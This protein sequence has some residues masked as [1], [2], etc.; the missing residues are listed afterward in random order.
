MLISRRSL[1]A[2]T[3]VLPVLTLP[4]CAG[5][6]GGFNLV[7]VIRRLLSLS[8]QRAFASLMSENGFL[9]SQVARISLPAQFGGQAASGIVGTLL[10]SGLVRDRLTRTVN[11]AAE[12]GAAAAA[13]V[14]A[15]AILKVGIPNAAAIIAGGGSGATDLLKSAMGNALLSAMVPGIEGGLKLFDNGVI[16]EALRS[17]SGIDFAGLRNDVTQKASDSIYRA[18][19]SEEVAIRANP[20]S[21]NDPLL[22]GVFGIVK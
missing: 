10:N 9:S 18:I 12:K 4:G 6:I 15:D 8:S 19:A 11:R 22:M 21:T 14:V 17:V 13:P 5:G 16:N 3:A 2:S 1:I 20:A 7:E